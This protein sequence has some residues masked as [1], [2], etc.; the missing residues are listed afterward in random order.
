MAV[1]VFIGIL[2][3]LSLAVYHNKEGVIEG[4]FHLVVAREAALLHRFEWKHYNEPSYFIW[5]TQ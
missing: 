5:L 2:K 3:Y 1:E 4:G